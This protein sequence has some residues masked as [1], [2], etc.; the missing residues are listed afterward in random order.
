MNE[1]TKWTNKQNGRTNKMDE[2][3]KWTNKQNGRT[4]KMDDD[5]YNL[6]HKKYFIR[7]YTHTRTRTRTH[8]R[9]RTRTRTHI[10][11]KVISSA[12]KLSRSHGKPE[13]YKKTTKIS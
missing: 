6:L 9:T 7:D 10:I 12:E 1:Q 4:N 3:T 13:I 8:T 2:Q 11:Y 5:V